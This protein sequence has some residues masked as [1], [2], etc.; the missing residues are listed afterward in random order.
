MKKILGILLIAVLV[1]V[2]SA[3]A[4]KTDYKFGHIRI[5]GKDY[6]Y[7]VEVRSSG[8]VLKWWRKESHVIDLED[9]E[10]TLNQKP[11]IIIIGTGAMGIAQITEKARKEIKEQGIELIVQK[12]GQA[13]KVFNELVKQKRE[14]KNIIALFHLTC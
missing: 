14:E 11:E 6:D 4:Q 3:F 12:T 5:L 8:E 7:D 9:I 13:V 10:R 1:S 2:S